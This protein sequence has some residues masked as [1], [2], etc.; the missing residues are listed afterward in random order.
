MAIS[1]SVGGLFLNINFLHSRLVPVWL[2]VCGLA[3]ASL[4]I[5]ASFL[6]MFRIIGI[7]T[8]LYLVLNVPTGLQELVFAVW[9]MVK[10]L[11]PIHERDESNCL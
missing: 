11:N 4:T 8:P 7:I 6:V 5:L 1:V 3:G 9:L 2:S 10:G